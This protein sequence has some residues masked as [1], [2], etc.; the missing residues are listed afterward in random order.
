M[1]SYEKIKEDIFSL[2]EIDWVELNKIVGY[3]FNS[4]RLEPNRD[5]FRKAL[6]L[7]EGL[8]DDKEIICLEGP[9]MIEVKGNGKEITDWILKLYDE[10]GYQKI[11]FRIWFDRKRD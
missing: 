4:H 9:K 2:M 11:N 1:K 10:V 6:N 8:I 5:E 7:I 3:F